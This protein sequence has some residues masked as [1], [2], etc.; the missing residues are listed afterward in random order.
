MRRSYGRRMV[1]RRRHLD[2]R[3]ARRGAPF[4]RAPCA[5]LGLRRS[6]LEAMEARRLEVRRPHLE[7]VRR[8]EARRMHLE[9]LAY[10][11]RREGI[12]RAVCQG[13]SSNALPGYRDGPAAQFA[14]FHFPQLR[15]PKRAAVLAQ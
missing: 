12:R 15:N 14:Q 3:E 7:E 4:A 10:C 13:I 5:V 6:H 1:V 11:S 8:M 9:V 2:D